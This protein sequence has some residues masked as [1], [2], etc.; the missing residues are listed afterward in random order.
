MVNR[1]RDEGSCHAMS[2]LVERLPAFTNETEQNNRQHC[3]K[4]LL[5]IRGKAGLQMLTATTSIPKN[6]DPKPQNTWLAQYQCLAGLGLQN[7]VFQLF[8][9]L[10]THTKRWK[11]G[12]RGGREH[13]KK[14]KS[15]ISPSP[16]TVWL[17]KLV[18]ADG[19]RE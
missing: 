17:A 16:S 13:K 2:M 15:E 9:G 1:Q 10:Y 18:V 5:E 6:Q 11:T 3:P 19:E 4:L 14:K 7:L 8:D 12:G